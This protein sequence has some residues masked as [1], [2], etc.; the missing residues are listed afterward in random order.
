MLEWH[1]FHPELQAAF[2]DHLGLVVS[3]HAITDEAHDLMFD[4]GR[5]AAA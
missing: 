5:P 4:V 1:L 2:K 3:D